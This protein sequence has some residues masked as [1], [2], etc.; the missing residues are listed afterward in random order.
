MDGTAFSIAGAVGGVDVTGAIELPAALT[1]SSCVQYTATPPTPI[2]APPPT[3][4]AHSRM[5][6]TAFV[7]LIVFSCGCEPLTRLAA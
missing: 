5:L 4:A 2:N 6:R 1:C 3:N 7:F